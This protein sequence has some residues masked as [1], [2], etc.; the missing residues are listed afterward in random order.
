MNFRSNWNMQDY[1]L[2]FL[3]LTIILNI[4]KLLDIKFNSKS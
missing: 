3:N 4:G 1:C 2:T